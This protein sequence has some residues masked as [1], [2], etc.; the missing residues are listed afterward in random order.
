MLLP[1]DGCGEAQGKGVERY[2]KEGHGTAAGSSHNLA[3]RV[4]LGMEG[5]GVRGGGNRGAQATDEQ[6]DID[7]PGPGGRL[8]HFF[9][10][11]DP[12]GRG[13]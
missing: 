9:I 1:E 8:A 5:H 10:L 3:G 2:G 11:L 7:V 12:E 6:T 4:D 13:I